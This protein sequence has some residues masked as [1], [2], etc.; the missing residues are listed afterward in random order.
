M[1]KLLKY[2]ILLA[3]ALLLLQACGNNQQ[4]SQNRG[5]GDANRTAGLYQYHQ[6]NYYAAAQALTSVWQQDPQDHEVM[7]A[8]MD[9]WLQLDEEARVWQMLNQTA[10]VTDEVAILVGELSQRNGQCESA[11][12]SLQ[13]V[14]IEQVSPQWQQRHWQ[15]QATCAAQLNAY[16]DAALAWIKLSDLLAETDGVM[17]E[18]DN[19]PN[20]QIANIHRNIVENL[21][22]VP[23]EQLR[24]A[25]ADL[26]QDVTTLGWLEAAYVNF[27]ADGVSGDDWLQRWQD[28]PASVFFLN[29]QNLSNRQKVAVLLPLSGRFQAVAKAFQTGML[30]AAAAEYVEANELIFFDT[31]SQG[32]NLSAAWYSAQEQAVDMIIGPL[33][34]ASIEMVE[35]MPAATMPVVLLNQSEAPYHQFTLSP[36][37]EAEQAADKMYRDGH[38]Q[39]LIMAVNE[40]WGERMTKAFAQKFVDLGG[41]VINNAYFLES[42][43]DYSAQLR[44]ILGLVESQLRAKNL[45][46][47]LKINLAA[48]VVVRPDVDAIFL[49]AK[50]SFARLMIP[51]LKFHHAAQ[52]PVYSTSHVFQGLHNTQHNRDLQGVRFAISPIELQADRLTEFLPFDL[53]AV[54]HD[55]KLFAFGYD[56]YHLIDRLEWMSQVNFGSI[57]GLS[58]RVN[59]DFDG[60]FYRGL[61][62]AQYDNGSVHALSP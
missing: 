51:Q 41:D 8:L 2:F 52:I 20:N 40:P 49:A 9:S 60:R 34:K 31:G 39:V 24:T 47:F 27:G 32:E 33:D 28:H 18:I 55:K 30:T 5:A 21:I 56:A 44:Q 62:W 43:N 58:G 25:L 15:L 6:Q 26:D 59:M 22:R 17:S 7:V 45:Q 37:G 36:E 29:S 54:D 23:D 1:L 13:Q 46:S 16:L 35:G 53:D 14:G 3:F 61:L 4:N 57:N 42:Q 48:E 10:A 11:L 12:Q 19:N 38:R 50:P